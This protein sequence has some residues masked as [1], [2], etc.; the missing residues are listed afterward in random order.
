VAQGRAGYALSSDSYL[1]QLFHRAGDGTV[2]DAGM[3][4]GPI[5]KASPEPTKQPHEG[6]EG[7]SISVGVVNSATGA[8]S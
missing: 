7:L 4:A 5:T 3:A 1:S 8:M 2:Y 6:A